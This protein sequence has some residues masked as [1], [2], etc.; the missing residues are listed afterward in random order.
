MIIQENDFKIIKKDSNYIIMIH[1]G[2]K[3]DYDKVYGYYTN[4][5][6]AIKGAYGY[7]SNK[8]YKGKENSLEIALSYKQLKDQMNKFNNT[9][10]SLNRYLTKYHKQI[11]YG[12]SKNRR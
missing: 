12:Y 5:N 6:A 2:K 9:V 10:N 11:D 8:K 3:S 4:L 1:T 7:R